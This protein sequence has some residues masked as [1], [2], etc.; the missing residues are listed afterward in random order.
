MKADD[1]VTYRRAVWSAFQFKAK[2]HREMSS[3]EYV[4]MDKWLGFNTEKQLYTGSPIPLPVVL[5]AIHDFEG[6]PRRLEAVV[7]QVEKAEAYWFNC[8]GGI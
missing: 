2:T 4:L 1:R 8:M 3:S 7:V 6:T 5:R